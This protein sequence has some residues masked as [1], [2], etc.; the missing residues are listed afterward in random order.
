MILTLC[1]VANLVQPKIAN[2]S[3]DAAQEDKKQVHRFVQDRAFQLD[4][5]KQATCKIGK[6]VFR[7]WVMDTDAKRQEGMMHLKNDDFKQDEGMIFIFPNEDFRRFWMHNT[8]VDLDITYND[9]E[10]RILNVY[11]MKAM[12]ETT[13][14]S[15]AGPAMSVIELKANT[16]KKLEI[17]AGSKW[18]I[19]ESVYSKDGY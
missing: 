19:P 5:L 9:K 2:F 13:D 11:T 3:Q 12:D 4:N 14:Y 1:L 18:E 17:E 10:G 7:L 16:L 8:L 15:S 6:H